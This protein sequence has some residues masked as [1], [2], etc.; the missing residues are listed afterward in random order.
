MNRQHVSPQQVVGVQQRPKKRL[1]GQ[2]FQTQKKS[3]FA[4]NP[5]PVSVER[6]ALEEFEA[7]V[8]T[9]EGSCSPKD[10]LTASR[11]CVLPLPDRILRARQAGD[12]ALAVWRH[13][14]AAR[15]YQKAIDICKIDEQNMEPSLMA[16]L[17]YNKGIAEIGKGDTHSALDAL[18][19]ASRWEPTWFAPHALMGFARAEDFHATDA[20][21]RHFQAALKLVT[22][23]SFAI[24]MPNG[25]LL[26]NSVRIRGCKRMRRDIQRLW[27]EGIGQCQTS[28]SSMFSTEGDLDGIVD[29][30]MLM[31]PFIAPYNKPPNI[32]NNYIMRESRA[33]HGLVYYVNMRTQRV[34]WE[35]PLVPDAGQTRNCDSA[36]SNPAFCAYSPA[37]CMSIRLST[38]GLDGHLH[39]ENTNENTMEFLGCR[40]SN[41]QR[42]RCRT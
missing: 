3:S 31:R 17:Y 9:K 8:G 25:T 30:G 12:A 36:C 42:V 27:P 2:C 7:I 32:P 38:S 23:S 13:W 37:D 26:L 18:M 16:S 15:C 41:T 11:G 39:D 24:R 35:Q 29:H 20:T 19:D 28:S 5:S 6:L 34:Q 4:Q 33:K 10:T 22:Q 40:N 14:E 21:M 1:R